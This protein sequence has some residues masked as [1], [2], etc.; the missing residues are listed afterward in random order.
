M[1]NLLNCDPKPLQ[2]GST[3]LHVP[4]LIVCCATHLKELRL[5]SLGRD[6]SSLPMQYLTPKSVT[7]VFSEVKSSIGSFHNA[8][9]NT[10]KNIQKQ[11]RG[12]QVWQGK[13]YGENIHLLHQKL[14]NLS[15]SFYL[16]IFLDALQITL[17][18][19]YSYTSL[20]DDGD[21]SYPI[22]RISPQKFYMTVIFLQ[23]SR[24]LMEYVIPILLTNSKH[25]IVQNNRMKMVAFHRLS[26]NAIVDYHQSKVALITKFHY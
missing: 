1:Y 19:L 6:P 5:L 11:K 25:M 20:M 23:H 15:S 21:S 24:I 22:S 3:R 13:P 2:V 4:Q 10:L 16:D 9:E 12:W 7:C 17:T 8:V 14:F 18:T 26:N